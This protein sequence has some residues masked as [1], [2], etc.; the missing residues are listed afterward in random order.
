[1]V[2]QNWVHHPV[3]QP[4]NSLPL[5]SGPTKQAVIVPRLDHE[6][7]GQGQGRVS[8]GSKS[9]SLL[10]LKGGLL[11]STLDHGLLPLVQV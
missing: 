1:M 6:E 5:Q 9:G 11:V 2:I 7:E 10:T 8:G 4:L 3:S